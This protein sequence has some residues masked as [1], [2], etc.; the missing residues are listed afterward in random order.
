MMDGERFSLDEGSL[1]DLRWFR[2]S[3]VLR[4]DLL[5][6]KGGGGFPNERV[7]GTDHELRV[8]S[9]GVRDDDGNL[10]VHVLNG[11][12][13]NFRNILGNVTTGAEEVRM[14]YD[15]VNTF[16]E[17]C[18]KPIWNK[19]GNDLHMRCLNDDGII[20]DCQLIEL[21]QFQQPLVAGRIL[22][23][24]IHE[25][26]AHLPAAGRHCVA[27]WRRLL[28]SSNALRQTQ[29]AVLLRL[30]LRRTANAIGIL[31]RALQR[32]EIL[33]QILLHASWGALYGWRLWRFL[34][35]AALRHGFFLLDSSIALRLRVRRD[36]LRIRMRAEE[37]IKVLKQI[38][39]LVVRCHAQRCMSLLTQQRNNRWS[40][41]PCL[42]AHDH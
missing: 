4:V 6:S 8:G 20:V 41:R 17:Q 12:G 27:R 25:E 19:R 38:R 3:D 2:R 22:G 9:D 18:L 29:R 1:V 42:R 11:I 23:A 40:G 5:R 39:F 14:A 28:I 34:L 10:D 15:L 13:H 16:I 21:R 35:T 30:V 26:D 37:R 7:D 31:V 24:M 33:K 32:I 36:A